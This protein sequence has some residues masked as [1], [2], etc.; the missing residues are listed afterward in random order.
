MTQNNRARNII[1]GMGE[2]GAGWSNQKHCGELR[3][4]VICGC[5]TLPQTWAAATPGWQ[6]TENRN[7]TDRVR[8]GSLRPPGPV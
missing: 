2:G 7:G 8:E 3:C 6:H 4:F 5:C 1:R